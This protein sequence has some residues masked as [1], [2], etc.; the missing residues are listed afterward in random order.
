M[1]DKKSEFKPVEEGVKVINLGVFGNRKKKPDE[2]DPQKIE[3]QKKEWYKGKFLFYK[4][5]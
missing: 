4:I 3:S 1:E 2:N 5:F